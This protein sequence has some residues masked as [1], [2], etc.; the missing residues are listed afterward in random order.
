MDQGLKAC[1]SAVL[2]GVF[3]TASYAYGEEPRNHPAPAKPSLQERQS[4]KATIP[5]RE[6]ELAMRDRKEVLAEVKKRVQELGLTASAEQLTDLLE[7]RAR[8]EIAIDKCRLERADCV[9]DEAAM[10]GVEASFRA[11]TGVSTREF[12][13]GRRDTPE[14]DAARAAASNRPITKA[15]GDT[16]TC[17]FSVYSMNRFMNRYWGLECNNHASHGVCSNNVDSAHSAGKGAMT[18]DI[19]LWFGSN[20]AHKE[21]PDDHQ[22]CFRG[23]N[24]D[25]FG[26]WGNACNCDTVHSQFYNPTIA[27]YGGDMTD[28]PSIHQMSTGYYSAAG[29]CDELSV[30]VKEFIKENDPWCCDDPMGDLWATLPLTNGPGNVIRTASA[31]N[32]NGGSQ[33]GVYPYC[34]TFGAD[35]HLAY[36]CSTYSPPPPPVCDPQAEQDC[37]AMGGWWWW[38]AQNCNCVDRCTPDGYCSEYDYTN[39]V[40]LRN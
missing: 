38:D 11:K 23:P 12:R 40:C 16:C 4:L 8:L 7:Q 17:T 24:T 5:R 31:Q 35:I 1:R 25:A 9:G 28:S 22:T 32:C 18:G 6:M 3:L 33:S 29:A 21:C 30:T 37:Y 34:G 2:L 10:T 36:I 15:A 27:W 20:Q 14:A 39:C 13:S 19:Y 26:E